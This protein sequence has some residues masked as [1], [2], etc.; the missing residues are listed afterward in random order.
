MYTLKI[1]FESEGKIL[2]QTEIGNSLS[3]DVCYKKK[4]KK[5][6]EIL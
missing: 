3:E 2:S 5:L 1:Y 4:K 6:K